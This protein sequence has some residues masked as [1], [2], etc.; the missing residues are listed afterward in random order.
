MKIGKNLTSLRKKRGLTQDQIA[1]ILDIKRAR[2]NSW[3]NDIARPSIEMLEKLADYYGVSTDD[4]LGRPSNAKGEPAD[5]ILDDDI[6]TLQRAARRMSEKDRKKMV[7]IIKLS[8]EEAFNED[9][10]EDDEDI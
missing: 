8:F 6:R 4:L 2:Y 3:E 10:D 7:D 5:D 9:D 1:D